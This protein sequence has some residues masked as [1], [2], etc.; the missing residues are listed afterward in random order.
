MAGFRIVVITNQSGLALGLFSEDDLQRMHA[1]L[2]R[3]LLC[4]EVRIDGIYYCPHHPEGRVPA[5]AVRCACRKPQP[6][7]LVQA[8]RDLELDLGRSWFVGDI[9]DDVEAGN[10]A[11]CRTVLVDQGT[12]APPRSAIRWPDFVARTTRHALT[13]ISA[14]N[15]LDPTPELGYRPDGWAVAPA[16]ERWSPASAPDVVSAHAVM[17]GGRHVDRR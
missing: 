15:R 4:R 14:L 17:E 10:R 12:E 16:A 6:G 1:H 9:L 7:L 2:E 3:E 11:G 13:I 8:A 5:L